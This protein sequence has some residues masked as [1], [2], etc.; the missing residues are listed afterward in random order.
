MGDLTPAEIFAGFRAQGARVV[1]VNHPRTP[2]L[3]VS[4]QQVQKYE[5]G[6]N[7]VGSGRL[8]AIAKVLN[9]PVD[10]FFQNRTT[11]V[12][13]VASNAT[14]V[15]SDLIASPYALRMLKA[16]KNVPDNKVR[17]SLVTLTESIGEK[18]RPI[19]S[20]SQRR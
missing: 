1:Q 5:N 12:E 3:G 6:S 10:R 14:D 9:V 13:A 18:G 8:A 11:G 4:F 17:L 2:A 15:V 19:K 20:S 16:L 7:R